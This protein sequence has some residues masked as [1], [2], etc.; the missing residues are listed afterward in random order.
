MVRLQQALLL[1]LQARQCPREVVT[2]NS[3]LFPRSTCILAACIMLVLSTLH[4]ASQEETR[5]PYEPDMVAHTLRDDYLN[6]YAIALTTTSAER[7]VEISLHEDR[8]EDY[9]TRC[10]APPKWSPDGTRLAFVRQLSP[11]ALEEENRSADVR[12][13]VIY[14]I[15]TENLQPITDRIFRTFDWSPDSRHIVFD[16]DIHYENPNEQ[17]DSSGLYIVDLQSGEMHQLAA[18][19]DGH[20]LW[21]P[22]WSPD[23]EHIGF[24]YALGLE[25][26]GQFVLVEA[27]GTQIAE[28]DSPS[29]G[30]FDWSP[31]GSQLIFD[32]VLY[33]PDSSTIYRAE[34]GEDNAAAHTDAVLEEHTPTNPQWSPDGEQIAFLNAID[35]IQ[36]SLWV[37]DP[38]GENRYQV[39]PA[40]VTSFDWAPDS[41]GFIASTDRGIEIISRNGHTSSVIAQGGC[42]TWRPTSR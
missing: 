39:A 25:G 19:I 7:V 40:N 33:L 28:W 2:V 27:D 14:D 6:D 30:A 18:P 16:T 13:L 10:D 5:E 37:A 26:L 38:D 35:D 8:P 4:V 20:P 1:I 32:T 41:A 36:S 9:V 17:A 12:E 21:Q 29:V 11:D 34:I 23:G 24:Y 3:S 15:H 22:D 31:D 42:P